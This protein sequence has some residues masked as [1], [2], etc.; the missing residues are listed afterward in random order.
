MLELT[1]WSSSS[2]KIIDTPTRFLVGC[3]LL[4]WWHPLVML[5]TNPNGSMS[6]FFGGISR[7]C[8]SVGG[9]DLG[10]F[11]SLRHWMNRSRWPYLMSSSNLVSKL[12]TLFGIM[13]MVMVIHAELVQISFIWRWSQLL[14]LWDLSFDFHQHLLPGSIQWSIGVKHP[15]WRH[16]VTLS[17]RAPRSMIP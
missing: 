4:G 6:P 5:P 7:D 10:Q 12:N 13:A 11:C 15:R 1:P 9:G 2:I 16:L 3:S 14:G 8:Y 17:T